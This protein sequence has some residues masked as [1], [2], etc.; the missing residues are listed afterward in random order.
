LV[1]RCARKGDQMCIEVLQQAGDYLGRSIAEIINLFNPELI[2]YS[3]DSDL[4][5][6]AQKAGW[7][8]VWVR[9]V[10]VGHH[11]AEP[12]GEWWEHDRGVYKRTWGR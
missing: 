11:P 10:Y 5:R 4:T 2:H 12:D 3:A 8:S 6:R 9:D 1:V 7:K